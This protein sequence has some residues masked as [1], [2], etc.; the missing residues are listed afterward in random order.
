[1]APPDIEFPLIDPTPGEDS[2]F[3]ELLWFGNEP[4]KAGLKAEQAVEAGDEVTLTMNYQ[5]Y[6][7]SL[8]DELPRDTPIPVA[9]VAVIDDRVVPINGQPVL[10]GSAIPRRLSWLPITV[11]TPT[12][13]GIH[14]IFVQQFP[15]PYVDAK[16]AEETGR[17]FNGQSSQRFIL[18]VE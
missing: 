8:A 7:K 15:N 1:M 13:P 16:E 12:D 11:K 14:Q 4:H 17:E 6:A 18:E 2:G 9:F 10:Y 5:P 3:M